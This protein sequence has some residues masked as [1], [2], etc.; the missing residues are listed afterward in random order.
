MSKM[1]GSMKPHHI[2][3]SVKAK[4]TLPQTITV[5]SNPKSYTLIRP[6]WKISSAS[7][8]SNLHP[9]THWRTLSQNSLD[10]LLELVNMPEPPWAWLHDSKV[11]FSWFALFPNLDFELLI[12]LDFLWMLIAELLWVFCI[13]VSWWVLVGSLSVRVQ[14]TNKSDCGSLVIGRSIGIFW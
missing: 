3:I 1:I 13:L 2:T 6:N 9:T 7:F 5:L 10:S 14:P 11:C 12:G 4:D 8:C